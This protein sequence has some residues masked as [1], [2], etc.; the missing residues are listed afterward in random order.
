MKRSLSTASLFALSIVLCALLVLPGIVS[1]QT[2]KTRLTI[3]TARTQNIVDLV[4]ARFK[5]KFPQYELDVLTMGAQQVLERVRGEKANPQAD[6]W[7]GGTQAQFEIAAQEG[8]L[9]AYKPS[10]AAKVPAAY[11]DRQ[12]RWY[13]EILLPE[14]IMYNTDALKPDQAPADWDDLLKP[15]FKDKI[16]IRG[17]LPSGTMRTIFSAM[18]YR[19]DRNDPKKGYDWLRRLDANTKKYTENPT[20]LY[21]ALARQEALVSLW[22][23]QDVMI[24]MHLNDQPFGFVIPK[25]GSIILVDGVGLVKGSKNQKAAKDF[26]EFLFSEEIKLL[27]A[28]EMYQIP[29]RSDMPA[30]KMP[31]WYKDLDLVPMDIDWQIMA[32]NEMDWMN[33]W[34]K[35]I[36]G[37]K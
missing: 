17:V 28:R 14:I 37:R 34:D 6:F 23:L 12:D 32:K 31:A 19:Q 4:Q 27:L 10:F 29:A 24:Q 33:Y 30:A 25:S 13:G 7:W 22:N 26:Y 11:R 1:A 35:N 3:Y 18:I 9:E 36:K 8:L 15:E 20:S 16:A 2:G 21:L 5:E